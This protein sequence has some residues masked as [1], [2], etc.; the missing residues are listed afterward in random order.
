MRFGC[1]VRAAPLLLVVFCFSAAAE[2]CAETL[3]HYENNGYT[4]RSILIRAP[5]DFFKVVERAAQPH[6]LS[7]KEARTFD[8][9][10]FSISAQEIRDRVDAAR[11]GERAAFTLVLPVIRDCDATS[12]T[13]NAQYTVYAFGIPAVAGRRLKL[14]LPE[15]PG[16]ADQ[17]GTRGVA[18]PDILKS[19]FPQ[20]FSG[21]D[22]SRRLFGGTRATFLGPPGRMF[23]KLQMEASGST[24]SSVLRTAMQGS[25]DYTAGAVQHA[26][27]ELGYERSDMPADPVQLQRSMMFG[28]FAATTGALGRG[29]VV[30][31]FGTSVEGGNQEFGGPRLQHGAIKSYLGLAAQLGRSKVKGTYG[32]QLG[33]A[34]PDRVLDYIRHVIDVSH[35]VRF[36]RPDRD[37]AEGRHYPFTLESNFFAG[38]TSVHGVLPANERF[39]GGNVFDP[40]IAGDSWRIRS[41]PLI[42]SF[43]QNRFN[44]ANEGVFGGTSALSASFTLAKTVWAKPLVPSEMLKDPTFQPALKGALNGAQSALENRYAGDS[45]AFR[46]LIDHLLLLSPVIEAVRKAAVEIRDNSSST[47]EA[48]EAAEAVLA[49]LEDIDGAYAALNN[50]GASPVFEQTQTLVEGF[51]DRAVDPLLTTFAE[52]IEALGAAAQAE[53]VR[54]VQAGALPLFKG[55]DLTEARARAAKD[56]QYPRL[57]I[58]QFLNE[59]NLWHVAPV[60]FFDIARIG[61]P[62]ANSSAFRYG[63]GGGV[64]VGLLNVELTVGYSFNLNRLPAE[65]RGAFIAALDIRDIFR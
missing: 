30:L 56:M 32:L 2:D 47:T 31:G 14:P 61:P 33:K 42:R 49:D 29:S 16:I 57:V 12:K 43:P 4:V 40:F 6:A 19:L 22:G 18:M 52:D 41:Q 20:L 21:Y 35:E 60:G 15:A 50:P 46:N 25:R 53:A 11:P 45:A 24:D 3:G 28:R 63:V 37:I 44:Y 65:G 8:T 17:D 34:Q 39:L 59:L 13:L 5:L 1:G 62:P 58:D 64:R 54:K 27:W 55:L 7:L 38:F 23:D 48:V 51:P 9:V 10:A 36:A 26:E